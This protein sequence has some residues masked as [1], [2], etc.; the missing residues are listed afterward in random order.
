MLSTKRNF[1]QAGIALSV[2]VA[3]LCAGVAAADDDKER[4]S[5][6][7]F[8]IRV[9]RLLQSKSEKLFGIERPLA[10]PADAND[11]VTRA[12][13]R[14]DQRIKLAHGL[15]AEFVARNVAFLGDMITFWPGADDYSHLIVCIEQGRSGTTP[16]G[17]GG[18]NA[19]VQ[20][21]DVSTGAV[22]TILHGMNRC[23][24]I[25]TTPWGTVLATEETE[26]GRAY[27]I[28]DPLGT[29]HHLVADRATGDIRD[30]VDSLNNSTK[31][32]QRTALPTMAW[33]GLTVLDSGVVIGGDELRP[34]SGT[35]NTDGGA[36]FKFVPDYP[37]ID[38]AKISDLSGSPLVSG[39]TYAMTVSCREPT[40]RNFPQYGQGCE[41][42]TGAWVK[43]NA[44]RARADA[45]AYGATG[46]YRPEDLH[47]DPAYDGD[48]ERFCWTNTGREK[49]AHYG[50]VICAVDGDPMPTNPVDVVDARTG[51]E[52]LGDGTAM[53]IVTTN[54]FVE[55]DPRFN[56]PDNLDFQ[57]KTGNVYVIEDHGNGEIWACLP[58]GT[59]Q[60]LKSDGCIAVA[61]IIDPGAEPTGFVFDA[62]GKVAY[63]IVQHGEQTDALLDYTSNPVNGMTDDLIKI[64]GFKIKKH[65]GID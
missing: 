52:Y 16:G 55:G 34:G 50:E 15:D 57:P 30:G 32:V 19:S 24:G 58:D 37:R 53:T 51:M 21:V 14:A 17:S 49:A 26:D 23:D 60:N 35:L 4:R 63:V 9:E 8:G 62:T 27:E 3:G 44:T 59:D 61:S 54:R 47:R 40:H 11:Y 56:S 6:T 7:D 31:V 46:Y 33:E 36:I 1:K 48:G 29:T 42:G 28:L 12:S 43:V 5:E 45:N 13:A 25:R 2:V 39:R 65:N 10:A 38:H 18:Y 20:R 41:A 22:E 64:T